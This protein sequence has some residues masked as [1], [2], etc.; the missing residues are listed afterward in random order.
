MKNKYWMT[1]GLIALTLSA[2]TVQANSLDELPPLPIVQ[3][4]WQPAGDVEIAGE[5]FT[6]L[7]S[8]T[9]RSRMAPRVL[10]AASTADGVFV[11]DRLLAEGATQGPVS[12]SGGIFVRLSPGVSAQQL[13][14]KYPLDIVFAG[15]D[16]VLLKA[17][18]GGDLLPLIAG[19]DGDAWVRTVTLELVGHQNLPQ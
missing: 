6:K 13:A 11:G 7:T 5:R 9:S 19:L 18:H 4:Q 17:N 16:I 14:A 15:K 1:P 10:S 3:T 2:V 12:V 8:T